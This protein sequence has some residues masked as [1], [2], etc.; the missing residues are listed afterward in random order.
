VIELSELYGNRWKRQK[1]NKDILPI[2][3]G[4]FGETAQLS[5]G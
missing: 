2:K 5:S 1:T 4:Y 3:S